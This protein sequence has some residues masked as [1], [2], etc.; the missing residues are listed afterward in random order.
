[1]EQLLT[2]WPLRHLAALPYYP[3][4]CS[5]LYALLQFFFFFAVCLFPFVF[6]SFFSSSI[7]TAPVFPERCEKFR[8]A[9]TLW[10][11]STRSLMYHSG[12]H[13]HAYSRGT[14]N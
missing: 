1:M 11:L 2:G 12:A 8:A 5:D 3:L 4:T 14:R 6:F 13:I 10:P 7:G 9:A